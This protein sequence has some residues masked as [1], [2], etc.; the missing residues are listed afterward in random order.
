M[1]PSSVA[2]RLA[3]AFCLL[4]VLFFTVAWQGIQHFSSDEQTKA[5]IED[6]RETQRLTHE[7]FGLSEENSRITLQVFLIENHEE[8]NHLLIERAA[9]TDR[10]SELVRM[11]Q[12][13]LKSE[14]ETRLFGV[15]QA[16]RTPYVEGYKKALSLLLT[17][18]KRD[19]ARQM[20]ID[21]VRP[22]LITYHN[23][24]NAFD[25]NEIETINKLLQQ[26]RDGN[27][28][29]RHAFLLTVFLAGLTTAGIAIFSV[30]RMRREITV[31]LRAEQALRL[32]HG[33]LEE[34]VRDRPA[35]CRRPT[36]TCARKFS[37]ASE[38]KRS[39]SNFPPYLNQAMT[40]LSA[41]LSMGS[42]PLGTPRLKE[43]LV[44][45]RRKSSESPLCFYFPRIV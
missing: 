4:I 13:R 34:R 45:R 10:I 20:M 14:E 44:T 6:Y 21:V 11:I 39:S 41:K 35:N 42:L 8:L 40:P 2:I 37:S 24:W 32:E 5:I 3:G 17:E 7:A 18:N 33:Q 23:A 29:D 26:D 12:P 15:V 27:A 19:Q 16:T 31:R 30:F 1:K 22:A 25:Q 43:C 28:A 36:K 9:N 38:L